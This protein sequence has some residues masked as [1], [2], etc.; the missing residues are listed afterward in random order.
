MSD[1][2][3]DDQTTGSGPAQGQD[4]VGVVAVGLGL[5]GIVLFGILLGIV[6]GFLGAW[7]GQRARAA[8]R[9]FELAYLAFLLAA[10]D[11]IVWLVMQ[12]LF[13]VPIWIG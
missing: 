3:A 9:S 4:P 10:V 12:G 8:G 6:A 1:P 5:L 13:E 11:G 2:Q 7:A